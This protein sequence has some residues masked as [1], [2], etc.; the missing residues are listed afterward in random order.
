MGSNGSVSANTLSAS[1]LQS[2]PIWQ[3]RTDAEGDEEVDESHVAPS[4]EPV[5]L[6]AY[7]SYLVAAT[8]GL[9]NGTSLPGSVQVDVLDQKVHFTPAVVYAQ[10]K[11]VDPLAHDAEQRLSRITK[12]SNTR[13]LH[14]ELTVAFQG[15]KQVR[16]GRIARS[17]FGTA[18]A[19]LV[20]LVLLRFGG[21]GQ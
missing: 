21:R 10:G 1:D 13:P 18:L 8:Y 7:G 3:F 16:R 12:S 2:H 5:A 17:T 9:K 14:W 6:G 15:E 20:R 4:I 19:L 11:P